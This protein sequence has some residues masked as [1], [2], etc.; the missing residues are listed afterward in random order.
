MTPKKSFPTSDLLLA[1]TTLNRLQEV[2]FWTDTQ[3]HIILA[4]EAASRLIGYSS[5]EFKGIFVKQVN[6]APFL[7]SIPEYVNRL[8]QENKWVY[9]AEYR[10]KSGGLCEMEV[11]DSLIK[12]GTQEYICSIARD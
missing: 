9:K 4:N 8:E 7:T 11:T 5:E 1:Q 6:N 10:K 12:I 3:G 2:I